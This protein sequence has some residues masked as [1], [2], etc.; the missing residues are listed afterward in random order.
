MRAAAA[1]G[2]PER[3]GTP[4]VNGNAESEAVIRVSRAASQ[5]PHAE[6]RQALS[7][8]SEVVAE[9]RELSLAFQGLAAL[10][11]SLHAFRNV[12]SL[13][14]SHNRMSTLPWGWLVDHLPLL[15]ELDVSHN[16][17]ASDEGVERL[18]RLPY[19]RSLDMRHNPV[20][21]GA[22]ADRTNLLVVLLA[23]PI[24][25]RNARERQQGEWGGLASTTHTWLLR[26]TP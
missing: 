10:P 9:L 11:A 20:C 4:D 5:A 14:L 23:R 1:R 16:V 19:L 17:L 13:N 15:V 6:L 26:R 24:K 2:A 22:A 8:S 25:P 18:A 21:R 3:P 7:M 12:R